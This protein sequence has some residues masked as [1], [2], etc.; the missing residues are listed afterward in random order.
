MLRPPFFHEMIPSGPLINRLKCFLIWFRF[1]RDI[2]PR[3][4]APQCAS[5]HGVRLHRVHHT[6]ESS[7]AVCIIPWSQTPP[8]A[9]YRG[10]KFCCVRHIAESDF[11]VCITPLSHDNKIFQKNSEMCIPDSAVCIL[12][13][14]QALW[15][16]SHS[17]VKLHTHC[18]S[19]I[20]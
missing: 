10:V 5:S 1:R 15:C 17:W 7:S 20:V 2:I 11:T 8:C 19:K 6:A 12:L 4:Q 13:R 14:S 16:A 3:S 18:K 9:S